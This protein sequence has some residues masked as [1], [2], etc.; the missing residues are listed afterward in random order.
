MTPVLA[1]DASTL[2]PAGVAVLGLTFVVTLPELEL[3][4]AMDPVPWTLW[5]PSLEQDAGLAC[6]PSAQR[7]QGSACP[8]WSWPCVTT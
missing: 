4:L 1:S 8:F 5:L 7:V 3:V 6:F 2:W